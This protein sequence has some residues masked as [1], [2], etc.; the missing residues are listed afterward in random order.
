MSRRSLR[1][2]FH[3][4]GVDW[5]QN[6]TES[7]TYSNF[8]VDSRQ[9]SPG[10]IF[11]AL[12][13]KHVDGH[14]FLL[15]AQQRGACLAIVERKISLPEI[16]IPL[17]VA[18]NNVSMLQ[19]LAHTRIQQGSAKIIGITG[20]VGKTTTKEFVKTML[21]GKMKTASTKANQNSQV[22]LALS[23]LNEVEGDEKCLV[24]EMGMTAAGQIK[25]LVAIAPPDIALITKICLVHAEFFDSLEAIARAKAEILSNE[26]TK[27]II[28]HHNIAHREVLH[29]PHLSKKITYCQEENPEAS[30]TCSFDDK[31]ICFQEHKET[32][33][34]PDVFFP[35]PHVYDAMLAACTTAR[36]CGMAWEEIFERLPLLTLPQKRL[37]VIK[38]KAATFINDSYSASEEAT[39]GALCMLENFPTEGRRIAVLGAMKELGIF[40]EGCHRN[41]GK[42]AA[43]GIDL[44]YC[45][46]KECMPI[47]EERKKAKKEAFLF[48]DFESLIFALEKTISRQDVVLIK[49][50]NS[51]ALWR[52]LDHF[53][54]TVGC[55]L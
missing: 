35:A 5:K 54:N 24:L 44:V 52:V 3:D 13:G 55:P 22:G 4:L 6:L 15:E 46:G 51:L 36:V 11:V 26:R 27:T 16:K 28:Y 39:L 17:I 41:V 10:Y 32:F 23:L 7:S 34:C 21:S 37:E 20:S 29:S 14:S 45:L 49:G 43:Q 31:R 9:V 30:I 48:E 53:N 50:S 38:T 40:S 42:K 18:S 25:K 19:Q 8:V 1:S 2:L 12:P 47:I 33:Y